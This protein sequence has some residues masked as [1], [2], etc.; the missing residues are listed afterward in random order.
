VQI[1]HQNK[2]IA[3]H[4][5]HNKVIIQVLKPTEEKFKKLAKN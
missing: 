4:H 1:K 2:L 3:N 5:H